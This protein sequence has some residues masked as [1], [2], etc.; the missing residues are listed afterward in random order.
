MVRKFEKV[1]LEGIVWGES[2]EGLPIVRVS[3]GTGSLVDIV[4]DPAKILRKEDI[5]PKQKGRKKKK[6]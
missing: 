1:Y 2:P 6:E 3:S 5:C 4:V